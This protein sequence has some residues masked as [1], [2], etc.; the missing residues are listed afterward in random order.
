VRREGSAGEEAGLSAVDR[1]VGRRVPAPLLSG[2]FYALLAALMVIGALLALGGV[3]QG[4][5]AAERQLALK[6]VAGDL[7]PAT[8][9]LAKGEVAAD[10]VAAPLREWLVATAPDPAAA[11]AALEEVG[12]MDDPGSPRA[13]ARQLGDVFG[14]EPVDRQFLFAWLSLA[15]RGD[16]EDTGES[17]ANAVAHAVG[18][19]LPRREVDDVYA[20]YLERADGEAVDPQDLAAAD[21]LAARIAALPGAIEPIAVWLRFGALVLMLLALATGCAWLAA[22][23]AR[24]AI[25]IWRTGRL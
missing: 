2:A 25:V 24:D 4:H 23:F 16:V 22:R 6:A 9:A 12:R 19:E 14:S 20:L 13:L 17:V 3:L 18:V 8:L 10:A 1:E 5:A 7:V 21:A 15:L 11:R